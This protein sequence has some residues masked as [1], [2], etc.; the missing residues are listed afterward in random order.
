RRPAERLRRLISAPG[1]ERFVVISRRPFV[2][3][4]PRILP[5]P[6]SLTATSTLL[7][8]TTPVSAVCPTTT[9]HSARR[10]PTNLFVIHALRCHSRSR[11][12][13]LPTRLSTNSTLTAP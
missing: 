3:T 2:R 10:K 13:S 11:V 1:E 9:E 12:Q 4:V 7:K 5:C 6:T 8:F